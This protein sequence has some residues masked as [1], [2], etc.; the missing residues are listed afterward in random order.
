MNGPD[1]LRALLQQLIGGERM[2]PA[3]RE[4]IVNRQLA[5]LARFCA[6][7]SPWFA[8]RLKAAGMQADDLADREAL[9]GLKLLSR[10]ELQSR[11]D[12]MRCRRVPRD[13]MPCAPTKTSGSSGEPVA[14]FRTALNQRYWLAN[15]LREH[16]WYERD[17]KGTMVAI[18]ANLPDNQ[19]IARDNWGVP[20]SLLFRSG[21]G[22][23]LAINMPVSQQLEHLLQYD[24]H[25]LLVYPSNLAALLDRIEQQQVRLPRLQQVRSIGETLS[26]ELRQRV[27]T[28]LG[29]GVADGYSSQELGQIAMQCPVSGLYHIMAEHLLVEVL[30]AQGNPCQPGETGRVVV[31]DMANYA[32]PLWRYDI[33][34]YAEVGGPCPCGRTLPTLASIRGR[35][36]NMVVID[37]E[38]RWPLVGFHQYRDIAP[39]MQYQLV[40]KT[41]EHIEAR[42]VVAT[43]VTPAQESALGDT[44]R[45]A[46][47]HDFIITFVYYPDRIPLPPSGKFEEFVCEVALQRT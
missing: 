21:P 5:S 13:H 47:G 46:L 9:R 6:Q 40:Q 27:Q 45:R 7:H 1:Q 23:G 34:D 26:P 29:V 32:T 38:P 18:R 43:P 22:Y 20:V 12:A 10:R 16:L 11:G 17:F 41:T 39:V 37:G 2:P 4:A 24:P 44:I 31:T 30:D 19:P 42:F 36:R 28:V 33:G 14:V 15:G 3:Q 35:E 25:Y 8:S